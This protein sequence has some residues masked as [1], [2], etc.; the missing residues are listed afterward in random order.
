MGET[1]GCPLHDAD[2]HLRIPSKEAVD[3]LTRARDGGFCRLCGEYRVLGVRDAGLERVTLSLNGRVQTVGDRA[4]TPPSLFNELIESAFRLSPMDDLAD[5]RKFTR[6][7]K[8]ECL[9]FSQQQQALH[10]FPK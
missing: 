4:G 3:L 7:R 1:L 6:E 8:E 9:T 5:T 2:K 10:P